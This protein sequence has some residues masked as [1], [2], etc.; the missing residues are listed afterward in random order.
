MNP[1]NKTEYETLKKN[2]EDRWWRLNNLYYITN[3]KGEKVLFNFND[4]QENLFNNLWYLNLILKSRQHGITTFFCIYFLDTVIFHDNIRAGIIAHNLDDAEAF[5]QDKV[6]YAYDNLPEEIK[7]VRKASV[8]RSRE[9]RLA[10]NSSIRI[11]TSFRSGNL[12]FLH[13]SEFGKICAKYPDKAKEIVTGALNTVH[14]GQFITIESTAEGREGY[15]YDYCMTSQK[16]QKLEADRLT[17]LDFRFFF[18][19]WFDDPRNQIDADGVILSKA[20]DK[21]FNELEIKTGTILSHKQKAWYSKKKQQL[22]EDIFR[23][24]P[25]TPGEAFKAQIEGA[26][27]KSEM[28][29]VYSEN[30][31][32]IFPFQAGIPV[33]TWWDIGMHDH[34]TIWFSQTVEREIY[35][36]DFFK[37]KDRGLPYYADILRSKGYNYGT[38]TLPHDGKVREWGSGESR[39]RQATRLLG[40]GVKVVKRTKKSGDEGQIEAAREILQHCWFHRKNCEEGIKGLESYRKEWNDKLGSYMDVPLHDWASHIADSF[41]VMAVAHKFRESVVTEKAVMVEPSGFEW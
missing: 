16:Q 3:E 31:I 28:Q 10:N 14:A 21:Y 4:V 24:H 23:E 35:M 34:T 22:G 9:L 11:N 2:L 1:K 12:Q 13:I 6:K 15:F 7:A 19:P 5:F 29:R 26:Y 36:V 33:D 41:M 37:D 32:A 27:F 20:L 25:S 39:K 40:S 18:F 30:R 8:D 17:S 38:H